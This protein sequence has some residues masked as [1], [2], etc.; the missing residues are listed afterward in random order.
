MASS[1]TPRSLLCSGRMERERQPSSECWLVFSN[2]TQE[3]SLFITLRGRAKAE[4]VSKTGQLILSAASSS[5]I[6]LTT[7][8][9]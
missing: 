2:Q 4:A 5:F 9:L 6:Y 1:P 3:V 7:M 8:V